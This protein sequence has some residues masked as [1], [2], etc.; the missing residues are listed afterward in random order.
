M[1]KGKYLS[2]PRFEGIEPFKNKVW[3]RYYNRDNQKGYWK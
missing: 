1:E 2:D 3:G